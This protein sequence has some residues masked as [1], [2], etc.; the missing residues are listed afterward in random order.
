[1]RAPLSLFVDTSVWSLTLRRDVPAASAPVAAL[2]RALE[3]GETVKSSCRM[4][5][6]TTDDDFVH[7]ARL[8]ALKLWTE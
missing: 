7:V 4:R 8:S 1:M 2:V 6:L 5:M 3:A